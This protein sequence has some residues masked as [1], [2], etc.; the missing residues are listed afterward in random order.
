MRTRVICGA[1][2]SLGLAVVQTMMLGAAVPNPTVTGP[3]ASVA[4]G[5]SSH[6]YPFYASVVDLKSRGYVEEE[7]FIEGT[8]NQYSTPAQATGAVTSSG[9]PY[10][11]RILVRRPATAARFNGTVVLEW[12]NVTASR[13]LDID[14]F[15][16]HEYFLRTGHA[17]VGVTAQRIGVEALKVWNARRY[18]S[19]D[20]THGGTVSGDALS[21]D[22]FAQAAQA[23]RAPGNVNVMGGLKVARVYATGH[24]QSA[25]RL[26]TYVN[27][28]HPLNPIFE[29]VVVHGGG[30]RIRSDLGNVKVWKLLAETDVIGQQAANRQPDTNSFRSWEVAGTS[31]VDIQFTTYSR[32]LAQRDGSPSAPDGGGAARGARGRGAGGAARG[33]AAT[34]ASGLST[35]PNSCERPPNSRIPFHYVMNAAFDHLDRWVRNGTLPPSAPPIEMTSVTAPAAAARDKRGNALGG[36]RLSQHEVPTAVNSGQNSGPGFC[37]LYGAHEPFDAATLASLY[38]TH[39]GYV[40]AVR[41]VTARN[42]KAGYILQADAEATIAEAEKADIGKR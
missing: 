22:V 9:H 4:P 29:A 3:L 39:A 21:Y 2:L 28:V 37:R 1:A 19:L 12:N 14:W 5:D 30:G 26:A 10:K 32:R 35:N 18:G 8:A 25:G 11:T 34:P 7:F 27:S 15:Q 36:I 38:P 13:D 17:W 16:S 33:G 41:D 40:K 6:D 31:H 42:L 23:V 24:S 20:V